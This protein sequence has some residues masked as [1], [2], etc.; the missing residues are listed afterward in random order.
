MGQILPIRQLDAVGVVTDQDSSGFPLNAFTRAKN[1]RFDDGGIS[2]SPTFKAINS[3]WPEHIRHIHG[4]QSTANFN[5]VL[6]LTKTYQIIEYN[7]GNNTYVTPE[8]GG[9]D[10]V[11]SA[12]EDNFTSTT[13]ADITYINRI[14]RTPI[15][16]STGGAGTNFTDMA[17]WP[18]TW[19]CGSLRAFGDFL[20]AMNLIEGSNTFATRVRFSDLTLANQEPSS[21]DATD[22]TKSAGFID[23]VEMKTAIVDGCALGP[24]FIL[25]SKDQVWLMEYVG[26]TFI[27]NTR[28]L[29][30]DTGLMSAN[31]VVEVEGKHYCFGQDDIYVHDGN[32]RQSIADGR[33]RKYIFQ[34]IDTSVPEIAFVQHNQHLQEIYFCYKSRDD[35][36]E[37]TTGD[38]DDRA[39]RAAVYNYKNDTWSFMDLPNVSSATV[40]NVESTET[41][42]SVNPGAKYN[43]MGGTYNSQE[44]GYDTHILFNR[45]RSGGTGPNQL[46]GLDDVLGGTLSYF[47]DATANNGAFLERAGID[48]DELSNVAGYKV[49]TSVYPQIHTK[50]TDKTFQFNFGAADVINNNPTYDI[51]ISFDAG[52]KV[53]VD[54]RAAGRYLSWKMTV[55]EL[56]EFNLLGLDVDVT[57]TGRR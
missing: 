22:T 24:N 16:R 21:W 10:V 52:S 12:S 19:R 44:S 49:I 6:G 20:I 23:L 51:D 25:Y 32:T 7:N 57:V 41:Y 38:L 45:Q 35:M 14:D 2:R 50:D 27:M 17:N 37:H 28:K 8:V 48:L 55:E 1:V 43:N 47:T 26:G 54:T 13:L 5:T 42:A 11:Q 34:G 36:A 39:N 18:S 31:C 29:F 53:K 30:N 46:V 56:R 3:Y 33:V 4:V 9:V 15:K 40:A